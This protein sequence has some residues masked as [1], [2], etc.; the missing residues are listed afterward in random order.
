MREL[1]R[2]HVP[3]ASTPAVDFVMMPRREFLQAEF[4]ALERDFRTILR[5][6]TT[7]ARDAR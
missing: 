1:F 6:S 5:R 7:S 4:E 2:R 3:A